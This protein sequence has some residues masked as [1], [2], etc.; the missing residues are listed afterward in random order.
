MSMFGRK[1]YQYYTNLSHR[2]CERC[3]AWH[4]AIRSRPEGFPNHQDGCERAIVPISWRELKEGRARSRRMRAGAEA[5][6][7]R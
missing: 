6:L 2:T 7:A 4:G 5:E 1:H 3:L